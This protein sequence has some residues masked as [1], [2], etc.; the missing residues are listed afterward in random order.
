MKISRTVAA[1]AAVAAIGTATAPAALA[2]G[3]DGKASPSP[4][5][6][7]PS[8][9]YG[10]TDPTYDGV[11]RQS[12]ALLAQKTVGATPAPVA[13]DWLTG[14]QCADGSFAAF[15]AAP[16]AR[17]G[18]KTPV[19]TNSTAA[20][21]QA[22]EALG[23][24]DAAVKEAVGWLR[25]V[26]NDDGGWGYLPGA[27]S[28]ANSTSLV[29]G[30]FAA[31]GTDPATVRS[32]KGADPHRALLALSLP[33]SAE[34][35]GAFAYQPDKKGDLVANADATAAGVLGARGLTLAPE[36]ADKDADADGSTGTDG[37]GPSCSK[38]RTAE[39]AAAN[40]AAHL[41][42]ALAADGHLTSSLPGAED[43]P[44]HGT[45]AD[46][47]VALTVTGNAD[48][49]DRAVAWLKRESADWARQTGPAAWAQ[50]VLTARAVGA[51]PRDF[52]STDLVAGLYATGP[53]PVAD[54]SEDGEAGGA[55]DHTEHSGESEGFPWMVFSGLLLALGLAAVGVAFQGAIYRFVRRKRG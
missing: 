50:L 49:A 45:T 10:T 27:P 22:L 12:L 23:G 8:G 55:E 7:L 42:R 11:W 53:A 3:A 14:Q 13:V 40:G 18:A 28:D 31:V 19:D 16:D 24:E 15:R 48:R 44:D 36:P 32:A 38:A 29:I 9:L 30:A 21:V 2:D 47:V 37:D 33:C 41:A 54:A 51:D 34:D 52:G 4:S 17:C 20:A 43:Q 6:K 35:G 26:Q 46:A 25:S 1:L 5:V 39:D